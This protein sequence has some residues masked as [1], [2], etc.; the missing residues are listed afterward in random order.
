MLVG[1]QKQIKEMEFVVLQKGEQ[2]QVFDD[3]DQRIT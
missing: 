1:M 2:L 3:I